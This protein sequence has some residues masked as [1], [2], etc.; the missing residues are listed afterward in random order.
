MD[1]RKLRILKDILGNYYSS[2]D[3]YLFYC[4]KCNHHKKKLSVNLKIDKFKCWICEYSSSTIYR[5]VKRYGA[6][7]HRKEWENLTGKIDLIEFDFLLEEEEEQAQRLKLPEEF[8]SLA[9][10]NRSLVSLPARKYLKDRGIADEDILRWKIGY[11]CSGEY[12]NRVIIP[13]FDNEGY[14]NYFVART[15][16]GSWKKY[17]N[18]ATSKDIIFNDLYI[19]W[20]RDLSLVEG[21]FDA[22]V[23]GTNSIPILGSTLKENSK[24]FKTIAKNKT[25]VY[26]ALDPDA[27][28]KAIKLIKN[29]LTY[30][31]ELYKVDIS[32]YSDV[33]EMTK[34]EYIRRKKKAYLMTE[35]NLLLY[36]AIN[37]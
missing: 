26:I 16:N 18:P 2:G 5:L 21:V 29:L 22:I 3:E 31:V 30:G 19:D 11:C 15:Y 24:L 32:P 33:G 37:L 1:T 23:A 20:Q 9:N 27:E 17:K 28:K 14:I 10:K 6:Y 13:S 8:A 7:D 35:E 34:E 36:Q 4:P 12:D 25:P